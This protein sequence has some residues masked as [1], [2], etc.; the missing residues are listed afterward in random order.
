MFINFTEL[1]GIV[2]VYVD[3]FLEAGCKDDPIFS[4]AL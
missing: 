1:V 2:G 3:D 4:A